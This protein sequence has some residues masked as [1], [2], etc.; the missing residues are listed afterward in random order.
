MNPAKNGSKG[1]SAY[2][3]PMEGLQ[4]SLKSGN[5]GKNLI[6]KLS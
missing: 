5:Q 1:A 4:V 3:A 2:I 6:P